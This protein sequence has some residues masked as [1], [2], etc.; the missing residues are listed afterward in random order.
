[1]SCII[2]DATC[3]FYT[4]KMNRLIVLSLWMLACVLPISDLSASEHG[5]LLHFRFDNCQVDST[6]MQN[7]VSLAAI[8]KLLSRLDASSIDSMLIIAYASPEGVYEHNVYLAKTRVQALGRFLLQEFPC[9]SD[10]LV[11]RSG[12][13]SWSQLQSFVLA[14]SLLTDKEKMAVMDVLN[15]EVNTGTKKWRMQQLEVYPY[16]YRRYYSHL[17]HA[18]YCLLYVH[19]LEKIQAH[20]VDSM[21]LSPLSLQSKLTDNDLLWEL[22]HAQLDSW[23]EK[24]EYVFLRTNLLSPLMHV[25]LDVPLGRHWSLGVGYDYPWR[26]RHADHRH[27][28]QLLSWSLNTRYWF[29]FRDEN[30]EF[31]PRTI[32]DD[33]EGHAIGMDLS[34]GYY[35]FERR[36]QGRQGEF[37][38]LAA[39]YQYV[40]PVFNDR[41]HLSFSL[42]LGYTYSQARPYH[43]MEKGGKAYRKGYIEHIQYWG[44]NRMEVA[45]VVPISWR[46]SRKD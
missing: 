35:D 42:S 28:F 4:V 10:K 7:E 30:G 17:R 43:V 3:R 19:P 11:L 40:M 1:M 46:V 24:R 9:L 15:A 14:D 16:L 25:G 34:M 23:R 44:I 31:L 26:W 21:V 32:D 22:P 29:A 33:M 18:A 8:R 2:S 36:Y 27:C 13:E 6:Y 39:S 12:G 38:S 20:A 37:L 41:M 45:L 5:H